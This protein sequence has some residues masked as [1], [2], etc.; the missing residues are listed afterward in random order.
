MEYDAIMLVWAH[1]WYLFLSSLFMEV[2]NFCFCW[3]I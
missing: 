3:K 1:I 2:K